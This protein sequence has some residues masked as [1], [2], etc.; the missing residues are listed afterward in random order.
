[1]G[2]HGEN[3][4]KRKDGRWEARVIQCYGADGK[5]KYRCL[6]GKT[7]LEAKTKKNA[8]LMELQLH[9]LAKNATLKMTF[10]QVMEEWMKSRKGIIKESTY[11]NYANIVEKH[12]QPELGGQFLT[13]I[14][15]ERLEQFLQNKL[16]NGRLDGNGGLSFKTVSDMR[17]VIRLIL[18]YAQTHGFPYTANIHI[19]SQ[20]NRISRI[21]VFT[22]PE[23]ERLEQVLFSE[24]K[25]LYLGIL[26]AL[27]A[28]LRIGEVCALQWGD[29]HF[30]NGTV[31][32]SKTMI[33][34]RN[35]TPNA[36]TKT[37]LLIEQ[38]KT[39]SSNRMIPLPDFI[40][41]YY[42]KHQKEKEVYLLTGSKRYME[43]RICLEKYKKVLEQ[44]GVGDFNFHS[45]RHTFAT[46]CVENGFDMKSLSEI[47][48]HS[49]VNITMQRYIHPSME[50]KKEQM[51]K[52]EAIS[53]HGQK[54]SQL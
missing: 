16:Q 38:P 18:Q 30:E 3:I 46:R 28:G 24:P 34:I 19:A 2:R 41:S 48:G 27:Y 12:L 33:R 1:M 25:P 42:K 36:A 45:L 49:N 32:V 8:A 4:R 6:Y 47:M 13:A 10:G 35:M 21:Q 39:Q 22:R 17:S 11:A 51:N 9:P 53:I 23:Q 26:I 31:S 37:K 20:G 54:N 52:L 50:L 14:T 7:Y 40:L 15:S 29:F 5:A 44:A 43:P